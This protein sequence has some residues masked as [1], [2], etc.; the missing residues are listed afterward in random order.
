ME[1]TDEQ[2]ASLIEKL[3]EAGFAQAPEVIEGAIRAIYMDGVM[4]VVITIVFIVLLAIAV[5]LIIIGAMLDND[6]TVTFGVVCSPFL[7]ILAVAFGTISNP[8]ARVFDPEAV[9]YYEIFSKVL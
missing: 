1:K 5:G 2:L 3:Q 7:L 6:D 4:Q 8:W 9:F